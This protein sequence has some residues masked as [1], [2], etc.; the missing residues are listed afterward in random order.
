MLVLGVGNESRNSFKTCAICTGGLC[1]VG[2][3]GMGCGG[4]GGLAAGIGGLVFGVV[5]LGE[6]GVLY[7]EDAEPV[8]CEFCLF[9][10]SLCFDR[11]RGVGLFVV[12]NWGRILGLILVLRTTLGPLGP[13]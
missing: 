3:G 11:S 4:L 6:E 10:A 12:L 7:F 2:T 1:T 8:N 13:G 9:N 5:G